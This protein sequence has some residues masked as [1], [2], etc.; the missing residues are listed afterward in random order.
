MILP[1]LMMAERLMLLVWRRA[2]GDFG[3]LLN[4]DVNRIPSRFSVSVYPAMD[5]AIVLPGMRLIRANAKAQIDAKDFVPREMQK[6]SQEI[7]AHSVDRRVN[8]G[9]GPVR[10][11]SSAYQYPCFFC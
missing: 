8:R 7:A 10:Q 3:I 1:R 11:P 4:L 2:S 9:F 5:P 6:L